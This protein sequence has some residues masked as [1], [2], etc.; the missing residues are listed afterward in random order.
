MKSISKTRSIPQIHRKGGVRPG[1]GDYI[2]FRRGDVCP[3][4]VMIV[5][6]TITLMLGVL[7][8]VVGFMMM[9]VHF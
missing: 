9:H 4:K 6:S 2:S 3:E 1:A 5:E 7:L 8:L